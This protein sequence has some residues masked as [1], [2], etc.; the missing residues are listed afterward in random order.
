MPLIAYGRQKRGF[1]GL[2]SS[3]ELGAPAWARIPSCISKATWYYSKPNLRE[4]I[5]LLIGVCLFLAWPVAAPAGDDPIPLP[6]QDLPLPG[7]ES[8]LPGQEIP[9][10]GGEKD[11]DKGGLP[12]LINRFN[13]KWSGYLEDTL[14]LEHIRAR[15]SAAVLNNSKARLNLSGDLTSFLSFGLGVV[16]EANLGDRDY[17]L[18]DYLPEDEA[19]L[20]P[21]ELSPAFVHRLDEVDLYFQEAFT[22]LSSPNVSFRI[23]RHKFYSGTGYAYNPI[24]LFNPKD[25]LDPTYET[26]GQDAAL[27][28]LELAPATSLELTLRS[29][30]DFKTVDN[31]I[32]LTTSWKGWDLAF[33]YTHH[34]RRRIDWALDGS[35]REFI[36]RLAAMEFSG[37]MG[38]IGIYGEGGYAF[39]NGPEEIGSL[40]RAVQDHERFLIGADYTFEWQLYVQAEYLRF[41]Q[42]RDNK[43]D[44]DLNDRLA[45][46]TGEIITGNQDTLYLGAGYPLTDLMDLSL[47][48]II[49]LNDPSLIL[50][51][52]LEW[53]L[54]PGWKLSAALNVPL[55]Q[56]NSSLGRLGLSGFVR[57]RYYF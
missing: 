16:A 49:N 20:I 41:G 43:D 30:Y 53:D 36:W 10:P 54:R 11:A 12:G 57:L 33:Q 22:T 37:E 3:Y 14:T 23:G 19:A 17:Q 25:P 29:G 42:G 5:S 9:L 39:I 56:E 34:H 55:G 38:G 7:Q 40:A 28:T 6:G 31:Q 24:D 21:P 50:N 26:R 44:L 13:L 8:T 1:A 46:L 51:P 52:W 2:T 45:Y 15:D 4:L 32:R 47:Y 18:L 48:T 35:Q 27:L